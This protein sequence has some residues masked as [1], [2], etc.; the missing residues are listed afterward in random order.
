MALAG[1]GRR[2]DHADGLLIET[3]EAAVALEI[4]QVAAQGTFPHE[5][6]ELFAGD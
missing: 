1:I 4:L 5:L 6:L 2:N 3:L